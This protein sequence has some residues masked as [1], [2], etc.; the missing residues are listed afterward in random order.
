MQAEIQHGLRVHPTYERLV[1]EVRDDPHKI[2]YPR[3]VNLQSPIYSMLQDSLRDYD[4]NQQAYM[5]YRKSGDYGPFDP[6]RPSPPDVPMFDP[7]EAPA[8]DD[9]M[10]PGGGLPRYGDLLQPGPDPSAEGLAQEGYQPPPPPPQGP[11]QQMMQTASNSFASA[12]GGA[13]G[14]AVGQAAGQGLVSALGGMLGGAA[15]GAE[16]GPA[17]AVLGAV[18]G[19]VGG[20]LGS[21]AAQAAND[22]FSTPSPSAPPADTQM[23]LRNSFLDVTQQQLDNQSRAHLRGRA[24]PPMVDARTL[25]GENHYK[26]RDRKAKRIAMNAQEGGSSGSNDPFLPRPRTEP[27]SI[28]AP[29]INPAVPASAPGAPPAP[30]SYQELVGKLKHAEKVGPLRPRSRSPPR[31][32]RRPLG[33]QRGESSRHWSAM[34]GDSRETALARRSNLPGTAPPSSGPEQFSIARNPKRRAEDDLAQTRKR[35]QPFPGGARSRQ[36]G[37]KRPLDQS[38]PNP[39]QVSRKPPPKP[40]GRLPSR[41][42]GPSGGSRRPPGGGRSGRS[43]GAL[44]T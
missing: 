19:A 37:T 15:L 20:A 14:Q 32:D 27:R 42:S 13:A 18:G 16:A 2:Q 17:G 41:P 23:G 24:P 8:D 30:P 44:R 6:P 12:A 43:G 21:Q 9:L 40:E 39:Q 11:I 29:V 7:D 3:R 35:P 22:A 10:G 4:L 34:P 26:P 1:A 36:G 31:G 38:G 25:N 33:V 5:D 28:D